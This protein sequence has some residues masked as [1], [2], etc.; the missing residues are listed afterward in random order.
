LI[1]WVISYEVKVGFESIYWT[2]QLFCKI[3]ICKQ[4][5]ATFVSDTCFDMMELNISCNCVFYVS[6][7]PNHSTFFVFN[8]NVLYDSHFIAYFKT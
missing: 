8:F 5:S 6:C 3:G 1:L 7:K 2:P 4:T